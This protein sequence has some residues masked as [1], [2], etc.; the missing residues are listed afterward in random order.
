MYVQMKFCCITFIY[1]KFRYTT[2]D[3]TKEGRRI[4]IYSHNKPKILS[5]NNFFPFYNFNDVK[6]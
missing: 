3:M 2:I 1:D 5:H 6:K 4:Y